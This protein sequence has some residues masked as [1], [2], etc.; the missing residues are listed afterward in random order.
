ML[1]LRKFCSLKPILRDGD[2]VIPL[3]DD[4]QFGLEPAEGQSSFD[5]RSWGGGVITLHRVEPGRYT[6]KFPPIPGFEPIPDQTVRL[7]TGVVAECVVQL[8]RTR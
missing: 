2:T 8:V 3:G 7:E 6:L 1:H 5:S 4:L